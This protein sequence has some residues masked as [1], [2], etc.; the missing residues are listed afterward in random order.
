MPLIMPS[1][2]QALTR[3][4]NLASRGDDIAS[5]VMALMNNTYYISMTAGTETSN[6]IK[7]TGQIKDQDGQ[8]VS[9]IKNVL[10]TSKPVS[11][12]GTMADG[13][14]GAVV[15]GSASTNIWMTTDANGSFQIDV[16]N[17]AAEQNLIK[18]ELDNGT[19]EIL[20]LTF[21]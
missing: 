2:S 6:V 4:R 18:A 5:V 1:G 14:N 10:V 11:G 15:A 17:A 16:T 9:G 12:A 21:A 19:T 13:G 20:V 7:V 3:I 8:N